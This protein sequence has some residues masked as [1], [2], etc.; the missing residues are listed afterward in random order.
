MD[1]KKNLIFLF[2]ISNFFFIIFIILKIYFYIFRNRIFYS[3]S[4][5]AYYPLAKNFEFNF[6]GKCGNIFKYPPN[7]KRDYVFLS[8][9]YYEIKKINNIKYNRRFLSIIPN[10]IDSYKHSIPNAK[11]ILFMPFCCTNQFLINLMKKNNITVII[12]KGYDDWNI[13][14]SR[15]FMIKKYLEKNKGKINRVLMADLPDIFIFGDI[16]AT[17]SENDLILNEECRVFERKDEK[18]CMVFGEQKNAINWMKNSYPNEIDKM[19]QLIKKK[20]YNLNAGLIIGG[21]NK[22][23]K[24]LNILFKDFKFEN[25]FNYGYDQSSLL[26]KYYFDEEMKKLNITIEPC[27]QRMCFAPTNLFSNLKSTNLFYL[28]GCS[29]VSIHKSIPI[30]W[31]INRNLD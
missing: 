31:I 11:I 13:V 6:K 14:N 27:S 23:L 16:F 19:N 9:K 24:F 10:I 15:F 5:I 25:R 30:N 29:P 22:T 21:Y 3:S 1:I 17:F 2:F 12:E 28:N 7:N 26:L 8:F 4:N 18:E 20:I